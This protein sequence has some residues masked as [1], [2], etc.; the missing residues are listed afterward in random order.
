[1]NLPDVV[2]SLLIACFGVA[3]VVLGLDYK[4]GTLTRMG[5]GFFPV[6][7]GSLT[8]LLALAAAAEAALWSEARPAF[9]WRPVFFVSLSILVWIALIKPAGVIPS[10][11]AL[12]GI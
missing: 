5:P 10:T 7:T 8:I 11:F 6:M 9:R 3:V 12:V 1:K 2:A 4:L